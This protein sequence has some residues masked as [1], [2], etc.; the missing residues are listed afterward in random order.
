MSES[1]WPHRLAHQ[2]PWSKAF[3]R[4]DYWSHFLLQEIFPTQGWN[5][6][7][8]LWLADS[9]PLSHLGSP[10]KSHVEFKVSMWPALRIA[11]LYVKSAP[12]CP[13]HGFT[14]CWSHR[15]LRS[16]AK[17]SRSTA[18]G[19]LSQACHQLGMVR[20]SRLSFLCI[21]EDT[22]AGTS[23][24]SSEP[25]RIHPQTHSREALWDSCVCGKRELCLWRRDWR[26]WLQTWKSPMHATGPWRTPT[27][28]PKALN[29]PC[30][31]RGNNRAGSCLGL[32]NQPLQ[33]ILGTKM[34]WLHIRDG[35]CPGIL[36]IPRRKTSLC[37]DG[38]SGKKNKSNKLTN[39]TK[40]KHPSNPKLL[41]VTDHMTQL[42]ILKYGFSKHRQMKARS[43]VMF[44]ICIFHHS[45]I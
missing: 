45:L 14:A 32:N 24:G 34:F 37:P 8:L 21:S 23:A 13:L 11:V 25:T 18:P 2:A 26:L 30:F 43:Q 6:C 22:Y 16:S 42:L 15:A 33:V 27:P 28:T 39:K 3:P 20:G 36:G 19:D 31:S 40:R 4:Q 44:W 1:V 29:T 17:H 5:L 12:V 10:A 38:A 9:L 41:S 35:H 7:L